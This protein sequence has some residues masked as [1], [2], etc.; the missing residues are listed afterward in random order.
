MCEL[1]FNSRLTAIKL[2]R[3]KDNI[4]IM[5]TECRCSEWLIFNMIAYNLQV[6]SLSLGYHI[7]KDDFW[8]I[9]S[10]EIILLFLDQ[11]EGRSGS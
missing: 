9:D 2:S 10:L 11:W 6:V 4:N 3:V 1:D 7:S 8:L 5:L